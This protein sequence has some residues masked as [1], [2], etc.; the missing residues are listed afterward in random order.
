M[1]PSPSSARNEKEIKKRKRI[2]ERVEREKRK[3]TWPFPT[4]AK[5]FGERGNIDRINRQTQTKD[6]QYL[7]NIKLKGA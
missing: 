5:A 4:I 3:D 7:D 2:G 1:A 6:K